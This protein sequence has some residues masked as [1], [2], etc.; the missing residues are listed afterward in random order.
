MYGKNKKTWLDN[1]IEKGVLT[2]VQRHVKKGTVTDELQLTQKIEYD[3]SDN[4]VYI[5]NA[6]PGVKTNRIGWRI[7]K[8]VYDASDNVTQ[9]G[10]AQGS[11]AFIYIWDKR[12]EYSYS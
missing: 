4:P 3:A 12:A 7:Q 6:P 11:D 10:W 5:G 9:A 2:Y 1:K 8:F